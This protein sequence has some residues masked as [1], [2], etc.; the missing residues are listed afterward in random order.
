MIDWL[1][2][3]KSDWSSDGCNEDNDK[4]QKEGKLLVKDDEVLKPLSDYTQT[5]QLHLRPRGA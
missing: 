3:W 5:K 1:T 2:K 4:H